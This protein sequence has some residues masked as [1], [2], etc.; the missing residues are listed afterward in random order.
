[1]K[2]FCVSVT[3]AGISAWMAPSEACSNNNR[4]KPKRRFS[5]SIL[6]DIIYLLDI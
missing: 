2:E 4:A 6:E 5:A 1:M 3:A